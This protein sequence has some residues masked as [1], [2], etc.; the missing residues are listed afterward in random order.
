MRFR[1]KP[2]NSYIAC[3]KSMLLTWLELDDAAIDGERE[4]AGWEV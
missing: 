2:K 3:V 1:G 4:L